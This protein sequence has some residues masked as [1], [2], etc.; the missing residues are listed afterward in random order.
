[1][2]AARRTRALFIAEAVTLAHA[3]RPA[4]LAN[5]LPGDRYEIFF[6]SADRYRSLIGN[7][8]GERHGLY[9]ITPEQFAERLAHGRPLHDARTLRTYVDDD[10]ALLERVKPDVVVGDL[11][12]SLAISARVARVPYVT[13]VNAYWSPY[14][15]RRLPVPTIP[16]T[17]LLGTRIPQLLFNALEPV[18]FSAHC[19]PSNTIRR[20]HGLE[21][22]IHDIRKLYTD[23]DYVVYPDVPELVPTSSLP[24]THAYTGPIA[25]SP[26]ARDPEWWRRLPQ[27]RPIIYVTMGSSGRAG[28]LRKIVAA[29]ADEPVT[30]AVAGVN[31]RGN[32]P[33]NAFLFDYLPG[34]DAAR[35]AQ[36]VISNGGS[37][38]SYQALAE[39]RPVLGIPENMDQHVNMSFITR[40]GVGEQ[41]RVEHLT[42]N[43]LRAAVRRL[44]EQPQYRLQAARMKQAFGKYQAPREF[45]AV[46][47]RAV[48]RKS[49]DHRYQEGT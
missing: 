40:A 16:L 44:L 9:S 21:G 41:I 38:T 42:P 10:L 14:T 46:L 1:V 15:G 28:T 18:I 5:S 11:R 48:A 3:A 2:T 12:H 29:L 30:L 32:V 17:R 36:L 49:A 23:A 31:Y 8:D 6:A 20:E 34:H 4:F 27:E 19:A 7:I 37:P 22:S 43:K 39:G 47:Q 33:A 35:R 45:E 26:A 13:I 24:A 25:W